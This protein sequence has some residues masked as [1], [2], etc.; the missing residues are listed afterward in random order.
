M[1]Y[2][3]LENNI[4]LEAVSKLHLTLNNGVAVLFKLLTHGCACYVFSSA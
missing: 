4:L 3:V 1:L 2:L